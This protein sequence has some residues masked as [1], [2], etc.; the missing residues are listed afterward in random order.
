VLKLRKRKTFWMKLL[1]II[2][3]IF[4]FTGSILGQDSL[5][6]NLLNLEEQIFYAQTEVNR[7]SLYLEKFNYSL[8]H[9][10]DKEKLLFEL[11]RVQEELIEDSLERI[12]YLWN[13]SIVTKLNSE[14]G[15][16]NMYFNA[17][18][19]ETNET[20]NQVKILGL[21]IKSE[22]SSSTYTTFLNEHVN[23]TSF[24]CMNC[25]QELGTYVLPHK[26]GYVLASTIF[27]GL[28][29]MLTGDVY[30]GLGSLILVPSSFI[31]VAKLWQNG[32]YYNAFSWGYALIPRLYLGNN[33][34]TIEKVNQL[35]KRKLNKKADDC[36][37]LYK[38]KLNMYPILYRL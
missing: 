24:N 11:N 20:T 22:I 10:L 7:N 9:N 14:F 13:S 1:I 2:K 12:K 38:K 19:N 28:G 32:M 15:Y 3:L 29:T 33:S 37:L 4:L 36:K 34:L 25:I 31:G 21:L 8:C 27:P 16:S 35:E 17:Y 5:S 18:L 26:K 23:D 6:L 30:N